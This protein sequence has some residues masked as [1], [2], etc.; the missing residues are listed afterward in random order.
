[1]RATVARPRRRVRPSLAHRSPS[2]LTCASMGGRA[3]SENKFCAVADLS[4][5]ASVEQF[6]LARLFTDLGYRDAQIKPKTSLSALKVSVGRKKLNYKPDFA[7]EVRKKLRWVC[8]AKATTESLDD[9]VDQCSSYCL[10]LNQNYATDDPVQF[11]MLSNGVETRLYIWNYHD[12]VLTLRFEDF[13][14]RN[15][16]YEQLVALVGQTRFSSPSSVEALAPSDVLTLRRRSISEINVDFAWCHRHIWRKENLSYSAAFMEFVKIVF[17]KLISDQG[18]HKS[19]GPVNEDGAV[20]APL[21]TVKFSRFW[22]NTREE[23]TPNPLDSIQFRHLL[24]EFEREIADGK[25]KRIFARDERIN[26]SP[27]TIKAIVGRLETVDLYS[28][29]SDLNGRLFETFLNATLRGKD[30]G[31]YFTPRSVVKLATRLARLKVTPQ[32][33]DLVIDSCCGTGGFLI[34]A[35]ADMWQ[36]VD[37]NRSLSKDQKKALRDKIAT[38]RLYGVD[39]AREPALARIARIN[40]YLHGDGGSSIF[41]VDALDKQFS[42]AATDDPEIAREKTELRGLIPA[43][44]WADVALTNPPFAKEYSR[45]HRT[46]EELL[47]D[48]DLAFELEPRRRPLKSVKSAI[49][50]L[51]R[52]YD[53]LKPGGRLVT[54]IDDSLLGGDSYRLLRTWIRSRYLVKAVVSL[55]GDAFQRSQARVKTSVIVLEKKADADDE[56]GDVFMYYCTKVGIDDAPRQRVLAIDE[57]NRE[58]ARVEIET[59]AS[60]Y[61][62]FLQGDPAVASH[63]VTADAISDR[64][65]VKACLPKP[66]RLVDGWTARG[67][68]VISFAAMVEAIVTDGNT[69]AMFEP[70][71]LI[72]KDTSDELI[73]HLRVSYS[74]F[75]EAGD[76]I[77]AADSSKPR[78]FKVHTGDLVISHINAVHGAAAVVPPPLD[79]CVVSNEYTVCRVRPGY[80][81]RLVWA[82]LRTPEARADLLLLSTGIGRSRVHWDDLEKLML[83]VPDAAFAKKL[84]GQIGAADNAEAEARRLRDAARDSLSMEFDLDNEVAQAVLAAFKPPQ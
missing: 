56:Q 67:V 21:A 81:V 63:V 41:Q 45:S 8:E 80:D 42:P 17:L 24:D 82:L 76:E 28:I 79:G 36:K 48:Y 66:S 30:L 2:A 73:T 1:M 27:E 16:K 60:L 3:T 74:G 39:V 40:M 70:E 13:V 11:F 44:G 53:L 46:E 59:V 43:L 57:Q 69:T 55:P 78:L 65:D 29:D 51:E 6:F 64:I 61:E 18:V 10:L 4:N 84:L 71:D 33:V 62:R 20:S 31:Q 23:D 14:D 9:W 47:D 38:E 68:E 5:E 49:L 75:A 83:P 52:Y 58:A 72:E 19:Y 77:F 22:I 26:L 50:F 15:E 34:E 25:K 54:V 35:L 32:H 12:P 7:F 37:A